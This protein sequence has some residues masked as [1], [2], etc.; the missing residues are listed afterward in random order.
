MSVLTSVRDIVI[1]S[2]LLDL[3][4]DGSVSVNA[5]ETDVLGSSSSG[6]ESSVCVEQEERPGKDQRRS[7]GE[8]GGIEDSQIIPNF[9]NPPPL[10]G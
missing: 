6:E 7:T 5:V 2:I 3:L 10:T 9:K 4:V 8:V 1:E